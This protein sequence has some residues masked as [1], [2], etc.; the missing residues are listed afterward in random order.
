[1]NAM[2]ASGS[3]NENKS[4]T[5]KREGQE[6]VLIIESDMDDDMQI[7][8]IEIA[9]KDYHISNLGNHEI[10]QKLKE[11]FESKY[12]PT[13]NC[14]VGKSFGCKINAQKKH[15]LCF[16]IGDKTVILYKFR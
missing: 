8:A 6:K 11:T 7:A 1:M 12:Y 13:W 16:Q 10:A 9:S 3:I 5:S 4:S 14:I 2:N 15:Y